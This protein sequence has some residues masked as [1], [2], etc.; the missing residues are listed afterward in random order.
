M[1]VAQYLELPTVTVTSSSGNGAILKTYGDEVGKIVRLK[2][3]ELG[4]SYE[5]KGLHTCFRFL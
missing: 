3:V 4:R 2:T 5:T 1:V